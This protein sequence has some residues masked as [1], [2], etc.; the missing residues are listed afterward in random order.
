MWRG[1]DSLSLQQFM[2]SLCTAAEA[3]HRSLHSVGVGQG[4]HLAANL[5]ITGPINKNMT[6]V[7]GLSNM[8]QSQAD[9]PDAFI[10]HGAIVSRKSC[11]WKTVERVDYSFGAP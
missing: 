3:E 11:P 10:V 1:Q 8:G 5:S 6:P 2:E 4:E 7:K 9:R